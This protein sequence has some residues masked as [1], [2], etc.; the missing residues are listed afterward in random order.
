[1]QIASHQAQSY[2]HNQYADFASE[3][4][5]K[6]STES[7]SQHEPVAH[8]TR[9]MDTITLTHSSMIFDSSMHTTHN[10]TAVLQSGAIQSTEM[11]ITYSGSVSP[12]KIADKS[13]EILRRFVTD[14]LKEQGIDTSV[15][16]AT[17]TIDITQL[18]QKEAQ[19]LVAQDGYFGVEQTSDRI[20]DFALSLAQGDVSKMDAIKQGIEQ[21]F[22]EA[23]EIFG[24]ALPQI[25]HDTYDAA[26][27]KLD[28]WAAETKSSDAQLIG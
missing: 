19:E 24:G 4:G 7:L 28:A 8:N 12:E 22:N 14:T 15:A 11:A 9:Q 1:M 25:S 20:V 2:Q 16:T 5:G 18:S 21:G 13:Y 6:V 3:R 26:L 23:L 17:S 10:G 27:E